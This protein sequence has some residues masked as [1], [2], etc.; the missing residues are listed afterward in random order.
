MEHPE[1]KH[2]AEAIRMTKGWLA[3]CATCGWV[4]Q[5]YRSKDEACDEVD[6]HVQATGREHPL[7]RRKPSRA[8]RS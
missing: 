1:K 2:D 3:L 7:A 8:D 6:E 4:G 5:N